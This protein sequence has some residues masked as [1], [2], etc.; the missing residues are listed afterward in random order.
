MAALAAAYAEVS[1]QIELLR[2]ARLGLDQGQGAPAVN[3]EQPAVA[4]EQSVPTPDAEGRPIL[5]QPAAKLL[6]IPPE[7][8]IQIWKY[9]TLSP[10]TE[11][12]QQ[13]KGAYFTCR[14]MHHEIAHE[15]KP[16][17]DLLAF[18]TDAL[19]PLEPSFGSSSQLPGGPSRSAQ[20]LTSSISKGF[21]IEP[22]VS[23]FG[24][25][26]AVTFTLPILHHRCLGLRT[27]LESLYHLYLARLKINLTGSDTRRLGPGGDLKMFELL[28]HHFIDCAKKSRINPKMVTFSIDH[29]VKNMGQNSKSTTLENMFDEENIPYTLVIVQDEEEKQVER[30]YYS[31]TRFRPQATE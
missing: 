23:R 29:L 22:V 2:N 27:V 18:T 11:D 6:N 26:E 5:P 21:V 1:R 17:R 13:W 20:A 8:R 16:H 24:S 30:T 9:M 10:L 14:Q 28:C 31:P 15:L 12:C 25:I 19:A 4:T 3:T 7:L